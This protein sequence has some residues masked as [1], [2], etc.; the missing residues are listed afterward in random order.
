MKK[1]ELSIAFDG[2]NRDKVEAVLKSAKIIIPY[3]DYNAGSGNSCSASVDNT[4]FVSFV[5]MLQQLVND[6]DGKIEVENARGEKHT[7]NP[8]KPDFHFGELEK[9]IAPLM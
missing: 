2:M 5:G 6:T 1:T 8:V 7:L 3:F 4:T 9:Q